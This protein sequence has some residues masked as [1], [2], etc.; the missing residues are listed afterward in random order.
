M[1]VWWPRTYDT[2]AN[3][4]D[5]AWMLKDHGSAAPAASRRALTSV[6]LESAS[7]IVF[8]ASGTNYHGKVRVQ[9]LYEYSRVVCILIPDRLLLLL[10]LS[11]RCG[12]SLLHKSDPATSM[13]PMHHASRPSLS[14]FVLLSPS[15]TQRQ[16]TFQSVSRLSR[17][18]PLAQWA[19]LVARL[20]LASRSPLAIRGIVSL[21]RARVERWAA[22]TG[23]IPR[24][25]PESHEKHLERRRGGGGPWTSRH[26][27]RG[28]E[29]NIPRQ[30]MRCRYHDS[31]CDL[32]CAIKT[33]VKCYHDE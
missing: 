30:T 9:I 17:Q 32:L 22:F 14:I 24:P 13:T 21:S 3:G 7:G 2:G 27:A 12:A 26:L 15:L 19:Q 33:L 18:R 1:C 31:Q 4:H 23:Q 25:V 20:W 5:L 10:L 11:R 8:W 6:L 28:V 29:T 16:S